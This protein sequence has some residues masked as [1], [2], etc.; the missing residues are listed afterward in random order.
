MGGGKR[1][2]RRVDEDLA[3]RPD[4]T[5]PGS[6]PSAARD[7]HL[8]TRRLETPGR[9]GLAWHTRRP[10]PPAQGGAAQSAWAGT[11]DCGPAQS[12]DCARYRQ[13]DV[14]AILRRG[15]CNYAGGFRHPV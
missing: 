11:L 14:A 9:T 8:Q 7:A 1:Q 4:D 12:A 10:A 6:A 2:D 13:S 15:T 5:G 3:L